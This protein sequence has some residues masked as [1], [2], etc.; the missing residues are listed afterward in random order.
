MR[1]A[2]SSKPAG[3]LAET[4][5]VLVHAPVPVAL[6]VRWMR[7]D[8][9]NSHPPES[10]SCEACSLETPLR[11]A[12]LLL[13]VRHPATEGASSQRMHMPCWMRSAGL[14]QIKQRCS[15]GVMEERYGFQPAFSA[16]GCCAFPEDG[17]L[18]QGRT[19]GARRMARCFKDGRQA[20]AGATLNLSNCALWCG[21]TYQLRWNAR[22]QT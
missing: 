12:R 21:R 2:A 13:R 18:L 4:S 17:P 11:R 1:S 19:T 10:K 22:C 9:S 6:A 20:L 3:A 8:A 5:S 14:R 16:W 15:M 7:S